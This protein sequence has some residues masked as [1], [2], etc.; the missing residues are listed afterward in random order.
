MS[1]IPKVSYF[2]GNDPTHYLEKINKQLTEVNIIR[3]KRLTPRL[4]D[5]FILHKDKMYLHIIINGMGGSELEPSIPSVKSMFEHLKILVDKGFPVHRILILVDPV[6]QNTVGIRS[7]E[8]LLKLLVRYR[9]L[10]L[11]QIKFNLLP[12]YVHDDTKMNKSKMSTALYVKRQQEQQDKDVM[13]DGVHKR[14]KGM[15]IVANRNITKRPSYKKIKEFLYHMDNT[16][17]DG[18][19]LTYYRKLIFTFRE[20]ISI[21][22]VYQEPIGIR[23]LKT[24]GLGTS[25]VDENRVFHKLI[26]Y[27]KKTKTIKNVNLL[28]GKNPI[29]CPNKCLLCPFR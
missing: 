1:K 4:I 22:T 17:N 21:D 20:Y 19:F 29:S 6:I 26:D 23:E 5:W 18:T 13:Y 25:F 15:W 10:K 9:G 8:L 14:T 28:Y 3:T 24:F 11:R 27:D 7:M 16:T 12:Y 2:N